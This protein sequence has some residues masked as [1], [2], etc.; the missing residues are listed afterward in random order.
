MMKAAVSGS[1]PVPA[2]DIELAY[3]AQPDLAWVDEFWGEAGRYIFS[4]E[5]DGILILPPNRVYK[6]NHSGA[7]L[8]RYL[9]DGKKATDI[10][11]VGEPPSAAGR[12][13]AVEDFFK[14]LA[15]LYSNEYSSGLE[16]VPYTFDFSRLP[17][18][19]EIAVTYR[20]NN[21]CLFCYA[22]CG[23]GIP[24]GEELGTDE[25]KKIIRIFRDEARIPFFS[26]SGGEPLLRDDLEELISHAEGMGLETNLVSNGTLAGEDRAISLYSAGLRTA[27]I[28]VEAPEAG[29]HDYLAGRAGAF[30]ETIRG[31]KAMIKAGIS[32]QTN[33]TITQCSREAAAAM[34]EFLASLGINRFAMNMY[35]PAGLPSGAQAGV[36]L[37]ISY[38]EIGA[39]VDSV[40]KAAFAA[41]LTFYWYSP[42]P[43]C[44][45]NPI[46]R[47]MGNKS[48]AA[49]D[50]LISVAANGDLLPCSSWN[51]PIGNL[52]HSSFAELWFSHRAHL[53]KHKHFAPASC[54]DCG[55]Y[56]ACQGA[57]PL[58]WR[59]YGEGLLESIKKGGAEMGELRY[60]S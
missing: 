6:I 13:R 27:Q 40:R 44:Y 21:S 46:A 2:G 10:F 22:G 1:M 52:L 19:G 9:K 25:W 5:E 12:C 51:E 47:G 38:D 28:S 55:S 16:R 20:C 15:D 42:T 32:V 37:S 50:G 8:I 26:F 7:A 17:I 54:G 60:E 29:L 43:F 35:I 48:C 59:S 45:Y 30:D 4:R 14:T 23:S 24:G 36:D 34:P 18:L 31:I 49:A 3:P 39:V 56:T 33:T 53:L 58:Y 41:G 11:R 57:C